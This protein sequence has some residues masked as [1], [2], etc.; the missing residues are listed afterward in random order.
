M[1]KE[2]VMAA[3]VD[4]VCGMQIESGEAAGQAMYENVTYFFCS[5]DC[6]DRFMANPQEFVKPESN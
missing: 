2:S 5:E 6:R 1:R 4:P 3:V